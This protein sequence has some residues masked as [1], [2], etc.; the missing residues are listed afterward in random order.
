MTA[1]RVLL[2]EDD[3]MIGELLAD[4]LLD[5]GYDVCAL[6][7][8]ESEAVAAAIRCKPDLMIV[9]AQLGDGSGIS[10]MDT[11]L[12]TGFVPHLFMTGNIAKVIQ[13]RPGAVVLEK[14]FHE[15]AFT[16]AIKRALDAVP[17]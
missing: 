16:S 17:A 8:T 10:A 12:R 7:M 13:Q 6:E 2:V 3:V 9:D 1:L 5:M 4:M 15:A 11:I 14:P